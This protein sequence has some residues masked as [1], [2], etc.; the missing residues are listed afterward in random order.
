MR[1]IAR[2]LSTTWQRPFQPAQ[3]IIDAPNKRVAELEAERWAV[4]LYGGHV[5]NYEAQAVSLKDWQATP[6][7]DRLHGQAGFTGQFA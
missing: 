7:E 1:F 2:V 4:G 3:T 6:F 5:E